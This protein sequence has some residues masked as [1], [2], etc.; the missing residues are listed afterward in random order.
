MERMCRGG[1]LVD[2][3]DSGSGNL[4]I[5][6]SKDGRNIPNQVSNE[7]GARF[8]IKFL[9]NQSAIHH[10]QIKFNGIEIPGKRKRTFSHFLLTVQ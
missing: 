1:C 2:A 10:I 3:T 9:P 6:I 4:E 5:T 7:G 8:R